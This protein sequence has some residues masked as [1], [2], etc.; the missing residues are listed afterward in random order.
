VPGIFP[1]GE[2]RFRVGDPILL[3]R[4]DGRCLAWKIGSIM[5]S[6]GLPSPK[7]DIRGRMMLDRNQE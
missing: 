6:E 5:T 2:E 4:S 3:E 1:E 7:A